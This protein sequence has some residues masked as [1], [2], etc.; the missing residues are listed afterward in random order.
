MQGRGV[1]GVE[2][3]DAEPVSIDAPRHPSG[4]G[5][6][7]V[8]GKGQRSVE[9]GSSEHVKKER[10]RMSPR[11]RDPA[12]AVRCV[13]SRAPSDYPPAMILPRPYQDSVC[14]FCL[15]RSDPLPLI[16]AQRLMLVGLWN[17][18]IVMSWPC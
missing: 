1:R 3:T 13:G 4:E 9:V 7:A 12:I 11:T 17:V 8:G 5:Q 16:T 2:T 15:K 10:R 6:D 14:D 18:I